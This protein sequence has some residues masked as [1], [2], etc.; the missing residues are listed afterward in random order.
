MAE[1]NQDSGGGKK[2]GKIRSKKQGGRVDLTAMVDLAFLLITFFMLTTSLNK[3]NAMDVTV[4]DKNEEDLE[5]RLEVADDRT[6]TILLAGNNKI[7][8]YSGLFDNP[9]EGPET[10]D[11]GAE[12]IRKVLLRKLVEVPQRT[13]DDLIVVIRPSDDAT[14]KNLV[15]ILDEMKIVDA[16]KYSLGTILDMES[17]FLKQQNLL[18]N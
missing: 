10:V 7:V 17:E 15:D 4:P 13:G 12:G 8:W 9:I 16:Q 11:Y 6:T 14:H 5:D 1:L 2:G 3:P 18:S